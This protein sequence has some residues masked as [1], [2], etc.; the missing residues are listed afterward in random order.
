MSD[1]LPLTP[2]DIAEQAV[3]AYEAGAAV[4][5]VHARN[6]EDGSPSLKLEHYREIGERIREKCDVVVCY[7]TGGS[8]TMTTEERVVAVKNL[9]PEIT[10]FTPGSMNFSMH[11][12]GWKE[13]EWKYGWEKEFLLNSEASVFSNSFKTIREYSSYFKEA[14]TRPEFE[15]F[16]ISMLN[17][18]AFCISQGILS[19]PLYLQFVLGILGGLP[20]DMES[21]M[22][23][24]QQAR[25]LVGDD[26]QWS[27]C[28]GGRNIFGMIA[29]AMT[30]GS[31]GVRVGME[32]GLM[33]GK[34]KPAKSNAEIVAKVIRLAREL[35]RE[36]A[37]PDEARQILGLKG[38][39]KVAF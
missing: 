11:P 16:D 2:G 30:M 17:N 23:L 31:T 3:G 26:F 9:K 27:V 12:L 28:G 20:G 35:D 13:R 34:G 4:V 37:T 21:L 10:S 7:T 36:T 14:G 25:R 24:L 22:V 19:K 33:L 18:L 29:A 1:Y 8:A 39:D 32:D 5:H 38:K 6:P 15:I